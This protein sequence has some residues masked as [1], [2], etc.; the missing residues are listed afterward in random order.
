MLYRGGVSDP[1]SMATVLWAEPPQARRR[2]R[3]FWAPKG[4]FPKKSSPPLTRTHR[5][6]SAVVAHSIGRSWPDGLLPPDAPA[7]PAASAA[8]PPCQ[9]PCCRAFCTHD[10]SAA[11]RQLVRRVGQGARRALAVFMMRAWRVSAAVRRGAAAYGVAFQCFWKARTP[12]WKAGRSGIDVSESGGPK[13]VRGCGRAGE[14]EN[15]KTEGAR[16]PSPNS[17]ARVEVR[18]VAKHKCER[19]L[20]FQ[21]YL[22]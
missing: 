22:M 15:E 18:K 13:G 6:G 20:L 16:E 9:Q 3:K 4:P 19:C 7:A 11:A 21:P 2:R 1:G 5:E 12:G 10:G 14:N 17:R 8:V